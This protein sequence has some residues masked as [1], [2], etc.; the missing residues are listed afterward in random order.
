MIHVLVRSHYCSP[1]LHVLE[2]TK[3][4]AQ[5][6]VQGLRQEPGTTEEKEE[7]KVTVSL[8]LSCI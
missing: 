1:G 3:A 6:L 8:G 4:T 5:S 2:L 7:K